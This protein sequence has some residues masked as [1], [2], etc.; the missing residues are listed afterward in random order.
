MGNIDK[1]I[2]I[3]VNPPSRQ[4]PETELTMDDVWG[5]FDLDNMKQLSKGMIVARG[6]PSTISKK[7]KERIKKMTGY[8][9]VCPVWDEEL[10]YKSVTVTCNKDQQYEVEY[11]L[12]YVHGGNSIS[13]T[14]DLPDNKVAIRS[15]YQCW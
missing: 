8:P 11:W 7:D 9:I 6:L 12:E 13:K 15:D 1:K 4:L 10:G 2:E 14:K 5:E 3:S